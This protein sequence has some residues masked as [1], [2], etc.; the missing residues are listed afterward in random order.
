MVKYEK[1]AASTGADIIIA[2]I[3]SPRPSTAAPADP[4]FYIVR[5]LGAHTRFFYLDNKIRA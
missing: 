1:E 5:A 3:E 4:H 2:Y